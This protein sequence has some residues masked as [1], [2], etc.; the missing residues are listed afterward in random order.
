M[1]NILVGEN[2]E[3][4]QFQSGA[5]QNQGTSEFSKN[6]LEEEAETQIRLDTE[7]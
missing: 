7:S 5:I 3:L 2:W 1:R 4:S 6:A